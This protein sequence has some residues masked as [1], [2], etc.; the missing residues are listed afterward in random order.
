MRLSIT[1]APESS[2]VSALRIIRSE[3]GCARSCFASTRCSAAPC[4]E[5]FVLSFAMLTIR[6]LS[7]I[8]S[9]L[10]QPIVCKTSC[11]IIM[12]VSEE[13]GR[14]AAQRLSVNQD[15]DRNRIVHQACLNRL[16]R[17]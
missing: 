8:W 16:R 9:A 5:P 1:A 4:E 11:Q 15:V 3:D 12:S 17:S 13:A 6:H 10:L 14:Q 7:F 2:R